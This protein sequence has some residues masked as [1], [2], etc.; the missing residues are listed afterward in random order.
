M[1]RLRR[2]SLRLAAAVTLVFLYVPIFIVV[3]YAFNDS[4]NQSWNGLMERLGAGGLGETFS[5]RWFETA[6]DNRQVIESF[7]LSL[8][9]ALGAT[10]VALL[11][12]SA[13]A[14]AVHRHRFFGRDGISFILVLPIALPGIVTGMA[15]NSAMN[16]GIDGVDVGPFHITTPEFGMATI[17]VGHATFCVV[18]VY[19]NVIARLRRLGHSLEEASMDLGADTWQTF[20]RITLPSLATA[21]FAGALLAFALSFDEIVV[22]NF[23]AGTE[24]TLPLWIFAN[25]ARPN[26]RPVVNVVALVMILLSFIP[27]YVSARLAGAESVA[28]AR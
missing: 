23:T 4:K 2:I 24:Q 16:A 17:I 10:V 28:S 1:A 15:L 13:A 22:T 11:L 26:I 27:V 21:L 18:V 9:A 25:F 14:F 19:N 8:Q 7:T 6:L 20:R 5:L 12:G 3:V